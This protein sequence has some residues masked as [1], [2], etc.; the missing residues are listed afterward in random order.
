M[1]SGS[2]LFWS[3]EMISNC[4]H[5]TSSVTQKLN[6]FI[7]VNGTNKKCLVVVSALSD[8]STASINKKNSLKSRQTNGWTDGQKDRQT[9]RQTDEQKDRQTD[10]QTNR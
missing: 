3:K 8:L 2:K 10:I 7:P 6:K 5:L 4:F 1:N 9:D